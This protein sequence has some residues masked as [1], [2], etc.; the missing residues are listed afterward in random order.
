MLDELITHIV[1]LYKTLYQVLPVAWTN[2]ITTHGDTG[3]HNR[4]HLMQSLE[5]THY[6]CNGYA[7]VMLIVVFYA[8]FVL[9][10]INRGMSTLVVIPHYGNTA[11]F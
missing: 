6:V 3:S 4:L 7:S 8:Q 9:F 5:P 10:W 11:N 2:R 1:Y